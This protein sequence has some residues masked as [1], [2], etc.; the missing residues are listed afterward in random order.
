MTLAKI[1]VFICRCGDNISSK[2]DI[3]CLK[4]AIYNNDILFMEENPYLCS[5]EGQNKIK[6]KV[7][8]SNVDRIVFA[9]CSPKVHEKEFRR[10]AENAGIN[11]YLLEVANI[12]EQCAWVDKDPD[13]TSRAVDIINSSIY[14]VKQAFPHEK[15]NLPVVK[16]ALVVGGG[17]SGITAAL[18]LARQN[19]KVCIV[20]KSPTIGGNMVKIGKVF[21]AD[22]L[23]EEC[24]MCS[25]GPLMG[26]VAENSN[27]KILSQ[28]QVTCIAGH[29]GNFTVDVLTG[30]KFV[31][32]EKCN[33]CGECLRACKV[34][35]PDEWNTN[36]STR[37]AV[38]RPFSQAVPLSY[39]I[40]GDVCVKCGTCTEACPVGAINLDNLEKKL[41]LD[42]GAVVIATGHQEL[43]PEN[44]EEFGYKDYPDVITQM[45]LARIL[46][47]NGP[48]SG[49]L[50]APSTGKK[51]HRIV[52][53]Q[54]VGSRDRK[55]GSIPHCST[56]CCMVALKHANYIISHYK[57]IE[58]YICYTDMRTPGTY[59]NY[60]FETQKKGEKTIRFI[61]G[62]VAEVKKDKDKFVARVEDTLGGGVLDIEADMVVLSCA[63]EPPEDIQEIEKALGVSLTPEM[64]IKEK[65]S[66]MEPTQTTVPGMFVCGTAKEAMDIT[67]SINMSRSA[68][69]QVAELISQGNVEIEPNFAVIDYNKCELCK[70]CIKSC[71]SGA[72]YAG[73]IIQI[74]PIACSGCGECISK[75]PNCAIS[76]PLS[77]DS[78]LFARIDG[79]LST[80]TPAI[81]AFLD[82]EIAYTAADNM[83]K[84][85]LDYPSQVR[86]IKV[87]SIL[88]LELKHI[89]YAFEMG[90]AGIF[91]GDG[92]GNAAGSQMGEKLIFKVKELKEGVEKAGIDPE[93]ICFYEAYLPHYKGLASKLKEF[94]KIIK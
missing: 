34:T 83:G 43:N 74:D 30:P 67:A 57:G 31:N 7:K 27:I 94:S 62:K 23:S 84:N 12:R 50:I 11:R 32:E 45:E 82:K 78:D 2:I 52:M 76:L 26:E 36:L 5:V 51:P 20:E 90:A 39:T 61:R 80:G 37:K 63:V 87:P 46:A 17:I 66:K 69:S 53:I 28:S 4:N 16:N 92:T 42:V 25:L 93:R 44:K 75:C 81:L 8:S 88:R 6:E 70:E 89:L 65:N 40:D 19:I 1:G 56:I 73:E 79:C 55:P 71:H 14:A 18:S 54:C 13:P 49:K 86:I 58:I 35:T 77:S 22:T 68:A 38:Y 72:A 24:A 59:E 9:A 64:F 60:Y 41:T 91:L 3:A 29:A 15:T 85:T 10:C 47:V 21:S 48:T 33:A